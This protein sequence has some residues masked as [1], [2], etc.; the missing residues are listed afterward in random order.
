MKWAGKT[1]NTQMVSAKPPS[2][3]GIKIPTK[4]TGK[5]QQSSQSYWTLRHKRDFLRCLVLLEFLLT[6]NSRKSKSW[7]LTSFSGITIHSCAIV[8]CQSCSKVFSPCMGLLPGANK[9]KVQKKHLASKSM[10][11]AI[12]ML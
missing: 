7:N 9:K 1:Q 3:I 2:D 8:M 6:V 12:V 5:T 4:F 10:R 11:T